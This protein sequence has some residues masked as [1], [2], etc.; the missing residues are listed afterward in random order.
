MNESQPV[1]G[2]LPATTPE[3]PHT[4]GPPA[5]PHQIGR[6]R[7]ERLLGEGGFGRVYLAHDDDLHRP[8]AIKVPHRHRISAPEDVEAYL[9]E[10]RTVARLDHPNIVPV[11]DVGTT[12]EGL[13]FVVSKYIEGTDL[14]HR[15]KANRLPVTQ[16]AEVVATV[17][18]TLHHAHQKGLVHRDIKPGNILLDTAGKPYVADF[19]LA[20]KE[21]DL[22]KGPGFAGTPNYM[23][24]E[25]ARGE[26]H[27][28]DGRS[29]IFSLGVVC[30]ELLTGRR[31]FRAETRDELLEQ[32][33]TGE[34][35]PPRQVDDTIPKELERICLKALAKRA[36][37]RYTTAKD[38]ADDLRHWEA[39]EQSRASGPGQVTSRPA[40]NIQ[41][42]VP[43]PAT[44]SVASPSTASAPA[45]SIS[46]NLPIKIVPRGLRSFDAHDA[47]FFLELVPGPRDR[48][49]LPDCIRFWKTRIEETDPDKTFAVGLIYGP[50]GGGKSSLVKAGLLPRL[51]SN[52]IAVHVEATANETASRLLAGLRKHCSLTAGKLSLTE[53]LAGLRRRHG[54][55]A[56]KKVL[57]VLDQFEQW[58]HAN[59]GMRDAELVQP[60]RQ[61]DGTRVQCLILVRDDFW[62][63]ITRFMQALE[64]DPVPGHN[65]AAVDLFDLCH[66]KKVLA[67]FGTLTQRGQELTKESASFLDQSVSGLAQ[68]GK[69]VPVRLAVF[70]EMLKGRPWT[71]ATLK[72]V[73]GA[74]GIGVSFLEETF[75]SRAANPRHRLHQKSARAVLKALLPES[76]LDIKGNMR[77][78]QELLE[79]SGYANRPKD[80]EELLRILDGEI[81]LITP[82]DPEGVETDCPQPE[83]PASGRYY[84]LTHDYLVR[85]LRDWLARKQKETRWGRAELRLAERAAAWNAKPE[86]R[87]LP[88]WWEWLNIRL[89][90]NRRAWT[91]SQHKMMRQANRHHCQRGIMLLAGVMVASF[92]VGLA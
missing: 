82:T 86:S 5:Y 13:P 4:G 1:T 81:R 3:M 60:L 15:I 74:E 71:L 62:M 16:S 42:V 58:L 59:G 2:P 79:V 31:P 70:G 53:T 40:V 36:S 75:G 67:A 26:G 56:G 8:V 39:A 51:S 6:Y 48:Q 24:P 27:R 88:A 69:V 41:V 7:V 37:E 20:L 85:P 30:Y 10:A 92:L 73:G 50:S 54:I 84:Q 55:T 9:A 57:L 45:T 64:V 33:A 52:V 11:H 61:C 47:D 43:P 77:P 22:G 14:K 65:S 89:F 25:Q 44:A 19:G 17:A 76:G 68:D 12:E 91:A 28:V 23:S 80:F 21:E 32:I 38:F 35:R 83:S 66:A 90:T 29:D 34:P 87:H 49:G 46:D 18:E 72:E 78:R 63:A